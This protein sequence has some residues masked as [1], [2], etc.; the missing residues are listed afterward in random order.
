MIKIDLLRS[1]IVESLMRAFII[2]KREISPQSG[3]SIPH[4]LIIFQ[5]YLFVLNRAPKP[6]NKDIVKDAASTIHT[7]L[8]PCP[9]KDASKINTGELRALIS[10]KDIGPSSSQS[11]LQCFTTKNYIERDRYRPRE[12]ITAKPIHYRH[13]V[14]EASGQADISDIR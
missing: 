8:N 11:L 4:R 14:D 3:N 7:D 1:A 9:L 2:I 5:K 10:D 6:L 13:Q 12:D